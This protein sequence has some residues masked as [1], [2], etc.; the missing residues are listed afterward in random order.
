MNGISFLL[1]S[2]PTVVVLVL[3]G[4]IGYFGHQRDW[5]LLSAE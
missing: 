5:T 1:R 2:I 4:G 3:L